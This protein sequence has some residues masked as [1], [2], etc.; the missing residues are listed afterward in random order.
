MSHLLRQPPIDLFGEVV[1]TEDDLFDW[2]AAVAPMWLSER[3]FANYCRS[4]N[5]ADKVRQSKLR[6]DFEARTAVRP[7]P[8][9]ARLALHAIV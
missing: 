5:V 6:G 9:H 2:V 1:V 8:W 3:S 4:W 7:Q